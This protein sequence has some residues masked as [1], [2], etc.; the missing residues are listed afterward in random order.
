ME[1]LGIRIPERYQSGIAKLISLPNNTVE[2]LLSILN[3]M[4]NSLNLDSIKAHA[5]RLISNIS[6]T[7]LEEIFTALDSL[8]SIK[9]QFGITIQ[10]FVDQIMKGMPET[11]NRA[12][13]LDEKEKEQFKERLIRFMS[14]KLFSLIV[15]SREVLYE[16]ERTFRLAQVLSN[17]HPVFG[18]N[19]DNTISAAI[20]GH[21]LKIHYMQNNEHQEFF[22]TLDTDDLSFLIST[23]IEAQEKA[24]LLKSMLAAANVP[25]IDAE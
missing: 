6:G 15:K 5:A 10:E 13:Q 1:G 20:I 25:Y 22:V 23:L 18:D 11:G 4:P 14:G 2:E 12:L 17:V 19:P 24:E 8:F 21:T 7:D 16:Q 3:E 9:N